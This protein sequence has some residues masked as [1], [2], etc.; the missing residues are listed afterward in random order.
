M[1][2]TDYEALRRRRL[3]CCMRALHRLRHQEKTRNRL[4][5]QDDSHIPLLN[6]HIPPKSQ[7]TLEPLPHAI[8]PLRNTLT[9]HLE[10]LQLGCL[11]EQ[12]AKLPSEAGEGA[13]PDAAAVLVA[14]AVEKEV[15]EVV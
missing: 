9:R 15:E 2:K 3:L 5:K 7:S 8:A 4:Q 1:G 11:L 6:H 10:Q 14:V 13:P 12:T